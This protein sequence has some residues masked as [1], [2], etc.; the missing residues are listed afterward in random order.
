ML[1]AGMGFEPMAPGHEPSMLTRLHQPAIK[2]LVASSGIEPLLTA[3]Q[4]DVLPL[5]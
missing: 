3:Y 4:A 2:L 5:N 1:V